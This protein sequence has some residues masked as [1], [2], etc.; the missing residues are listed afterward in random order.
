MLTEK[1]L[2]ELVDERHADYS[3]EAHLEAEAQ[4]HE[5]LARS[6]RRTAA[7]FGGDIAKNALSYAALHSAKARA[8][9][10]NL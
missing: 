8:F 1:H 6:Y 3:S 7:R 9:R 2:Q 5:E 10:N 4:R